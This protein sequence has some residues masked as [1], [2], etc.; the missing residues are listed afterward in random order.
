MCNDFFGKFLCE[1]RGGVSSGGKRW[2]T[3]PDKIYHLVFVHIARGEQA[4]IVRHTTHSIYQ[5]FSGERCPGFPEDTTE[6]TMEVPCR[7]YRG[8]QL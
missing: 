7:P 3:V 8:T 6:R 5:R 4:S 2:P 1:T